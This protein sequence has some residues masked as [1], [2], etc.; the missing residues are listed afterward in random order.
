MLVWSNGETML[1]G[2]HRMKKETWWKNADRG[3][4]STYGEMME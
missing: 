2:G 3:K 4:P 1:I